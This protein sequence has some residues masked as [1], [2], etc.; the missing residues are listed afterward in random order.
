MQGRIKSRIM[1]R[2]FENVTPVYK[3]SPRDS[4]RARVT[5]RAILQFS[6][7]EASLQPFT[8]NESLAYKHKSNVTNNNISLCVTIVD[9]THFAT[10]HATR[11]HAGLVYSILPSC[12]ET[13]IECVIQ[14]FM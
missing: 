5:D 6:Q 1:T 7:F 9:M 12:V 4:P 3:K 13:V 8:G 14:W 11:A 10:V 2:F